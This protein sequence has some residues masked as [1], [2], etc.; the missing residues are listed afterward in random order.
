MLKESLTISR[1]NMRERV[2]K[3]PLG[4]PEIAITSS[5]RAAL[6]P[7]TARGYRNGSRGTLRR[8]GCRRSGLLALLTVNFLTILYGAS[9][10]YGSMQSLAKNSRIWSRRWRRWWGP[11]RGTSRWRPARASGPGSRLSSLLTA[12]LLEKLILNTYRC[13]FIFTSI[14]LD[15]FQLCCVI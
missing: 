15:D 14:K 4:Y 5:S 10:Y 1:T 7:T 2:S 8:C 13:N 3:D 9:L 11:S 12:V 6:L